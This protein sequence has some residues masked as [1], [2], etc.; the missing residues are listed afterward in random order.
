M[1]APAFSSDKPTEANLEKVGVEGKPPQDICSELLREP[2]SDVSESEKDDVPR[3]L[4]FSK[5]RSIALVVTLT[6]ASFLN[7]RVFL[8]LFPLFIR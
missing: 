5:A 8:F 1:T 3:S 7:V 4:P 6:G 2:T